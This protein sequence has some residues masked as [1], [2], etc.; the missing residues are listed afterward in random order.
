MPPFR[1]QLPKTMKSSEQTMLEMIADCDQ[2]EHS[3]LQQKL[4]LTLY[5]FHCVS[6][7][8]SLTVIYGFFLKR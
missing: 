5:V 8:V 6:Y 3:K 4:E 2:L 1:L 7:T